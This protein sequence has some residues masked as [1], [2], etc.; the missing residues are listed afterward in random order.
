VDFSVDP[1]QGLNGTC[2]FI[3]SQSSQQ[4]YVSAPVVTVVEAKNENLKSGFGQCIAAMLG[5]RLFNEREGT[6]VATV[7]GV[8]TTGTL[9]RFLR[10]E[11][12]TA[13]LDQQEYHIRQIG[14][15][16]GIF[17]YMVGG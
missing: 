9:W 13:T 2:D 17:M 4:Q 14:K 8:V 5:A 6:G 15:I 7:F 3:L 11:K 16:L 12:E 10:L 1:A